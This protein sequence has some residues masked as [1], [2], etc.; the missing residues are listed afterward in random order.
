MD[1]SALKHYKDLLLRKAGLALLEQAIQLPRLERAVSYSAL[2]YHHNELNADFSQILAFEFL[3]FLDMFDLL[4]LATD[5]TE[6]E[7]E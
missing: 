3:L 7:G 4:E 1:D 5:L 2:N 6:W